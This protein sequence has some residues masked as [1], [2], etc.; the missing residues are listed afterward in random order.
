MVTFHEVTRGTESFYPVALLSSVV[1]DCPAVS[2]IQLEH[3]GY[4][5]MHMEKLLGARIGSSQLHA[6]HILLGRTQS[7][8]RT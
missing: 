2:F 7:H 4:R 1:L 6:T 3:R 8:G 5:R